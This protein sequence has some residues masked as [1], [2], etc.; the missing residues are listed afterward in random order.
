LESVFDD[1]RD[2][3]PGGKGSIRGDASNKH[4]VGIANRR[5][6]FQITEHR[7]ADILRKRQPHLVSSFPDHL[8]RATIPVDVLKTPLRYISCAQTQPYQ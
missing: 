5:P 3:I 8:Q 2:T 4:T 7:V 6:S 1:R